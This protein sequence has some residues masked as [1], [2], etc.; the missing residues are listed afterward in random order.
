MLAIVDDYS[1][2]SWV[3]F[4]TSKDEAFGYFRSLVLRLSV[5]LLGSLR[6][7]RSDNGT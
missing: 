2:Y 4:M 6:A 3:Y 5:D 7:I 1:R